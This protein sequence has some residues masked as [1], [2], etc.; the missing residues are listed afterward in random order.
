[1]L[2]LLCVGFAVAVLGVLSGPAGAA[3]GHGAHKTYTDPDE[4]GEEYQFQGEYSGVFDTGDGEEQ[5]FGLQVIA[6]D[7]GKFKGVAYFGGLPGDGWEGFSKLEAPGELTE[8]EVIL[9]ADEGT[10]T[11]SDGKAVIRATTEEEIGTLEKVERKSP[12]LNAEPPEGAIVLFDGKNVDQFRGAKLTDDGY[13]MPAAPTGA[14]S[15]PVFKNF[16]LHIEFRTPFMPT[17]RGQARGNSGVYLQDRYEVQ[18]LDSFGL[19]GLDNE[20]G[21]FYSIKAPDVNMCFPPL[22]WQT[23]DIDFTAAEYDDQGNKT[24]NARVTVRHNGVV[25]HDDIELPSETPGR[26]KEGPEPQGIYLQWHGNPVVYKN[27]WVVEK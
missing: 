10:A 2:R 16:T 20:C 4:A 13:L 21:G 9:R 5:K 24:K 19:E 22:T 15:K 12:T 14:L 18:V 1:M 6:L 26:K 27:I 17:A 8:G 7:D 11:I 23:Y 25:I 3:D